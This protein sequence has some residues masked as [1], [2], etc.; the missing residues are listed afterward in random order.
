[1]PARTFD[2]M[3]LRDVVSRLDV[4]LPPDLHG[5]DLGL[6]ADLPIA[7]L[8]VRLEARFSTPAPA[9]GRVLRVRVIPDDIH[10]PALD[11]GITDQEAVL[12]NRYRAA[13]AGDASGAWH[14]LVAGVGSTTSR[15]LRAAWLAQQTAT[16]PVGPRAST[17]LTARGLPDRWFLSA[18]SGDQLVA[19]ATSADVRTDLT[20]DPRSTADEALWMTDFTAAVEAGMGVELPVNGANISVL[21]AVGVRGGDDGA[22]DAAELAALLDAHRFSRGVDLLRPGTPTNNTPAVKAAWRSAPDTAEIRRR[23]VDPAVG[24]ADS[25]NGR[26]LTSALGIPADNAA[27]SRPLAAAATDQVDARAMLDL[28]WPVTGGELLAVML[29]EH[30]YAGRGIDLSVQDAV[31]DHASRYLRGRGP[32]PSVLIGRQPYGVLPA[33]SLSRWVS[34]NDG[35]VLKGLHRRLLTGWALWEADVQKLT[36]LGG[37]GDD[38][39]ATELI[40]RLMCQSPVPDATGYEATTVLPPNFSRSLPL[41]PIDGPLDGDLATGILQLSWMPLLS[42]TR[43][44]ADKV[45][46]VILPAVAPGGG[47]RLDSLRTG[48]EQFW[49]L[50]GQAEQAKEDLLSQLAQRALLRS[51]ERAAVWVS[52]EI[53]VKLEQ[54]DLA[55]LVAATMVNDL[56][57]IS[58]TSAFALT[59]A[60][61]FGA[62]SV[63]ET[64]RTLSELVAK[65][66]LVARAFPSLQF[67]Q[68]PSSP[69]HDAAVHAVEH[70]TT[71][72]DDEL[73]LLMGETLDVFTN[74]YDAWVTS[75]ATRRLDDL[76]TARPDGVHLGGF[77]YLVDLQDAEV[78]RPG[79]DLV[80]APS[81]AQA[82]TAAV[83]RHADIG[84]RAASLDRS[85]TARRFDVTS[86][87]VRLAQGILEA[88]GQGQPLSAVLGYRVERYLQDNQLSAHIDG[89]RH[90]YGTIGGELPDPQHTAETV[91]A[92][93]VVDGVSVWRALTQPATAP[94][95]SDRDQATAAIPGLT[96]Y[97]TFIADAL[98]DLLVAEGVHHLVTGDHTRAGATITALS[99]GVPPPSELHVVD[100]PGRHLA[101]PVQLLMAVDDHPVPPEGGWKNDRPRAVVAPAAER[102]A[103]A[104]LPAP[105][106]C[107]FLVEW[108]DRSAPDQPSTERATVALSDLDLCA[109]D[110][111][112]EAGADDDQ[113]ALASRVRFHLGHEGTLL[114]TGQH[115]KTVGWGALT[116][117]ARSWARV[118]GTSRPLLHTD[119]AIGP[120]EDAEPPVPPSVAA[121]ANAEQVLTDSVATIIAAKADLQRELGALGTTAPDAGFVASVTAPLAVFRAAGMQ[122]TAQEPGDDPNAIAGLV[123]RCV[124][125]GVAAELRIAQL[126]AKP[127]VDHPLVALRPGPDNLSERTERLTAAARGIYGEAV[128]LAPAVR[129]PEIAL[130]TT[131]AADGM[132]GSDELA[133]WL[134]EL[135]EVRTPTRRWWQ[136]LLA[137]ESVTGKPPALVPSQFPAA[138]GEGWIGGWTGTPT[139]W[140]PPL[141]V[142][143]AFVTH[144]PE[145]VHGPDVAALII[146]S[147]LE[148]V[149]VGFEHE[150]HRTAAGP[151]LADDNRAHLEPTGVAVHYNASGAR[152]PQSIVL[153]VPPDRSTPTWH[154]GDLLAVLLETIELSR[155]RGIEHPTDLPSRAVLPAVFVPEG[156]EGLSFVGTLFETQAS[157]RFMAETM[158]IR[159]FGDA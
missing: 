11:N 156:I 4:L 135:S 151:A 107:G 128:V 143:R 142:R 83:L 32:L 85:G 42:D 1:M 119:V 47:A 39:R 76:R 3:F 111:L 72:G 149:P 121:V 112:T 97:L 9:T 57:T 54:P 80:H 84:D 137:A 49:L 45:G 65:P 17:P 130:Q 132:P 131:D 91:P 144:A 158:H 44:D 70:L 25:T 87:S 108:T 63:A 6:G 94:P 155:F 68:P 109:L 93:D 56:G 20:V 7:L 66:E 74:R 104:V 88:V 29:S 139:D 125:A 75:L 51:A 103:R 64:T 79:A 12:A 120:A 123:R 50:L 90:S 37:T 34:G 86:A 101:V 126:A 31:R 153:A 127:E 129:A 92:H 118:F 52:H 8:P 24:M 134:G 138:D 28:L 95:A 15:V 141:H 23:E 35:S 62:A 73:E 82:A 55:L 98:S 78:T 133:D 38:G 117:L 18:Y 147:W 124:A 26:V 53:A 77:G 150:P 96:S 71:L 69:E 136:A 146:E 5:L 154:L 46:T 102:L 81:P 105:E 145:E 148:Q 116:A 33:S 113:S 122:G 22:R 36:R 115:D 14:D 16:G 10:V 2:T 99:R 60:D 159:R 48:D 43:E 100:A 13:A 40:A 106:D 67:T 157:G 140:T 19:S 152:P 30:L 59:L 41:L 58:P 114:P 27:L 61:V 21:L 110:V 89:L